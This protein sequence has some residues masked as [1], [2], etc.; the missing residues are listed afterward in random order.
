MNHLHEKEK[1]NT[2]I[3]GVCVWCVWALTDAEK[4]PGSNHNKLLIAAA[5]VRWG[6]KKIRVRVLLLTFSMV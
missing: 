4:M 6:V 1:Y 2:S 3:C 5:S